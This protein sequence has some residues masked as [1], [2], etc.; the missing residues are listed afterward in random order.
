VTEKRSQSSYLDRYGNLVFPS[1][2]FKESHS[3]EGHGLFSKSENG[4]DGYIDITGKWV[5]PPI[6][7]DTFFF[8]DGLAPVRKGDKWGFVDKNGNV[9]IDFKFKTVTVFMSGICVISENGLYGLIDKKGRIIAEPVYESYCYPWSDPIGMV[10]DGKIGFIDSKGNIII[11]FKFPVDL[12]PYLSPDVVVYPSG[13]KI[14]RVRDSK[15]DKTGYF[16]IFDHSYFRT[17]EQ[18]G[19]KKNTE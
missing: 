12:K 16:M 8:S 11:D 4:L 19:G 7:D 1:G 5:I 15:N 6:Y 18:N 2:T 10:K 13:D 9:S 14:F 17:S 3:F